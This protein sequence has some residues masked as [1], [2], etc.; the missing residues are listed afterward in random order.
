MHVTVSPIYAGGVVGGSTHVGRGGGGGPIEGI[1]IK[2]CESTNTRGHIWDVLCDHAAV[3]KVKWFILYI[4]IF[5]FYIIMV[6]NI[7]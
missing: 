4:I 2:V 6:Q 1:L 5:L 3:L 7:L